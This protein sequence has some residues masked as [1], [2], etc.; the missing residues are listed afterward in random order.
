MKRL[1]KLIQKTTNQSIWNVFWMPN[2]NGVLRQTNRC[3]LVGAKFS[4]PFNS[5][6]EAAQFVNFSPLLLCHF[7]KRASIW[8]S[9]M[10]SARTQPRKHKRTWKVSSLCI[11]YCVHLNVSR[12]K[13]D[14]FET[15]LNCSLVLT[16]PNIWH[17]GLPLLFYS[18]WF[19]HS[20]TRFRT[21]AYKFYFG[22]YVVLRS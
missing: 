8:P 21:K 15:R 17:L 3:R 7:W 2:K 11:F 9:C 13:T 18:L 19:S 20:G 5:Q 12:F 16:S 6:T 4:F 22:K 14:E 10:L 1:S